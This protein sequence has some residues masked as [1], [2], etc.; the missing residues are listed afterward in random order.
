M[1]GRRARF[2]VV[3]AYLQIAISGLSL[4]SYGWITNEKAAIMCLSVSGFSS[5]LAHK[6]TT[7]PSI[8]VCMCVEWVRIAVF[9]WINY[10]AVYFHSKIDTLVSIYCHSIRAAEDEWSKNGDKSK[11]RDNWKRGLVKNQFARAP[12]DCRCGGVA[13]MRSGSLFVFEHK[14]IIDTLGVVAKTWMEQT[15]NSI[16]CLPAARM[17]HFHRNCWDRSSQAHFA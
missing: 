16:C 17:I 3:E 6:H 5:S 14:E 10:H 1:Y 8:I 2:F 9:Q 11:A 13:A 12:G 15:K 7:H 4:E